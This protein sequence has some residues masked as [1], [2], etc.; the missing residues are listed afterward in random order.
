MQGTRQQIPSSRTLKESSQK[1]GLVGMC[2]SIYFRIIILRS[3][4]LNSIFRTYNSKL[5]NLV[6]FYQKKKLYFYFFLT[7]SSSCA[8]SAKKYNPIISDGTNLKNLCSLYSN[9]N[10][11]IFLLDLV[12]FSNNFRHLFLIFSFSTSEDNRFS[13]R[14]QSADIYC[15]NQ[16]HF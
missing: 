8:F 13:I 14:R 11:S 1:L 10:S 16:A 2:I 15:R 7:L 12:H 3:R 9:D 5:R 6:P 4:Y